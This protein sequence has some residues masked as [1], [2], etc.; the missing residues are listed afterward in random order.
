MRFL[1]PIAAFVLAAGSAHA[2][3]NPIPT[4]NGFSGSVGIGVSSSNVASNL[5]KGDDNERIS[6][7]GTPDGN[8]VTDPLLMLDLRYTLADSRTQFVLGNQVHDALRLDFTQQLGV[9]Q[10]IGNNGIVSAGLVFSG[11]GTK[12]VWAN[13]YAL[14]TD[15][16]ETKRKSTG[17]RLGWE[18]ILGSNFSAD[19]TR[20]KIELDDENSRNGTNLSAAD[21][22]LLDRNGNTTRF[23]L[24]YDWEFAPGHFLAPGVVIG[25]HDMDGKAM[26]N[27][28][29]GFKLDYGYRSGLYTLTANLYAGQQKFDEVNPLF[30]KKADTKDFVVGANLMRHELFGYKNVSGFVNAAYGKSDSDVDFYDAEVKRIGAGVMYKF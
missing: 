16:E 3:V 25:Q 19:V 7:R 20:R 30:G 26:S 9:R 14:N 17:V 10:E 12:D 21:A 29:A 28:S 27:D 1:T 6:N 15:R 11:F 23:N 5:Y 2:A 13:P 4:T 8:S 18:N 22:S 24:S